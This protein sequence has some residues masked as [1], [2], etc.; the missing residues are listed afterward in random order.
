MSILSITSLAGALFFM[1]V[2]PVLAQGQAAQQGQAAPSPAGDGKVLVE[3]LCAGCHTTDQI[4]RSSGYTREGWR[5]LIL[6][7]IRCVRQPGFGDHLRVSGRTFSQRPPMK[8]TL[9]PGEA[10]I[11]LRE[12]HVPTLGQRA[13][14]PMQ[15]PDGSIWWA[16]QWGQPRRADHSRDR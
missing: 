6:T 1:M 2:M 14:D 3:G 11:T 15:T 4:T 7:M 5:E 9:V 12:W 16:G 10:T 13:R 8:P